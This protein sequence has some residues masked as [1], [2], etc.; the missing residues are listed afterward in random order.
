MTTNQENEFRRFLE[1]VIWQG[2]PLTEKAIVARITK[3]KKAEEILG[4]DIETI[5]AS[6][7]AM[8]RALIGLRPVDTRGNLANAVRKYYEMRRGIAFPH[9]KG[10][11]GHA[12]VPKESSV[13]GKK[14][15]RG[16][17]ITMCDQ[18]QATMD[19]K[20]VLR[21]FH[22]WLLDEAGLKPNAADQYK[23]YIKKLCAAVD[24]VFG[25]GWFESLATD[26]EQNLLEQKL[27]LCSAFIENQIRN[28]SKEC[29]KAWKDWRSAFHRFEEFLLDITDSWNAYPKV[30]GQKRIGHS[31]GTVLPQLADKRLTKIDG[32]KRIVVA[33]YTHDELCRVFLGRLKTQSRYYPG[34]RL[35]FPTRLLT[36]IFKYAHPNAWI[37]WLKNGIENMH[38]LKDENGHYEV[39]SSVKKLVIFD[40]GTI[41]VTQKDN[42]IFEL[43]TRTVVK[44][45][46]RTLE[47]P[48]VKEKA[49]RGLRDISI[50]H[51]R[52]L[53]NVLRQ[54]RTHLM[55]LEKLTRL[56][57][58]FK[59]ASGKHLD[60]RAEREW[61]NAFFEQ[62]RGELD[63][64]EM[65]ALIIEDL[66]ALNME[67]ELMDTRENPKKGK[68]GML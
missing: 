1:G 61:V 68:N 23:S 60:P 21:R 58:V 20:E 42:S 53:E 52:P 45:N 17:A 12:E 57:W 56:F 63:T 26:Y 35:L 37:T 49:R 28:C 31:V 33:T 36:K 10:D 30:D 6:D 59:R 2:R 46:G 11:N 8:R 19:F 48:I 7:E 16:K 24:K 27:N 51:I 47:G 54:S 50:D 44:R 14:L 64:E 25:P 18:K 13:S 39:V 41:A 5:V 38:M 4:M 32:D 22:K 40:D 9:L 29:K 43:M 65:R 15:F 66:N 67:Y 62:Y 3:A 55:G 34:F